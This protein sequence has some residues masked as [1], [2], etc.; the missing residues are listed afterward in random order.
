M[1]EAGLFDRVP[2][3]SET[4]NVTSA[5]HTQL[6]Q[7]IAAQGLVLL[8]NTNGLPLSSVTKIAVIGT[9]A[10]TSPIVC[11]TGSGSVPYSDTQLITALEGI[12]SRAGGGITVS[13]ND[14]SNQSSA[15]S[16][17]G[18]SDVAII[19]VGVNCGEFADRST[20]ALPSG[21][22][23]NLITAV[24]AVKKT[25]VVVIAPAQILMPWANNAN[26]AAILYFGIPGMEQGNA[27]AKVLFGDVNP[28]GKMPFTIAASAGD[29][30]PSGP[31]GSTVNYDEKLLIGYR[32]F[33]SRGATPLYPFGHGLSYTTF[34]YSN[35]SASQTSIS[36]TLTNSGSLA[37]A[38]VA[39]LYLGFPASAGEP[40]KV[41][42]GFKKVT[43]GAG[44]S[45]P[46]SLSLTNDDL[47]T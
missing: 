47:S 33:D 36:F 22:G 4:A 18:S 38:E 11:G 1:F 34:N 8:K 40:P 19:V 42:K 14:G 32:G 6:A 39:Q 20:L 15:V 43:L 29:Y 21:Q 10:S 27:L 12:T 7:D 26:V 2:G 3:G 24:A 16:L 28:S 5:A 23:D 37:G 44:A 25:I 13:Y 45:T 35:L 46:V 30:V 17:A 9:V 41:L 31:G